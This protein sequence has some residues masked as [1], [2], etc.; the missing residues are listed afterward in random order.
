MGRNNYK[1]GKGQVSL[2]MALLLTTGA[3]LTAFA[4]SGLNATNASEETPAPEMPKT[5]AVNLSAS[6]VLPRNLTRGEL[7]QET[8]FR[9][10]VT[11]TGNTTAEIVA[12][13]WFLSPGIETILQT[14][15]CS[16]LE[17][18]ATCVAT[19]FVNSSLETAL[20]PNQIRGEV[21]YG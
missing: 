1:K 17:A 5:S 18:N 4:V 13:D 12:V 16:R 3:A 15:N 7:G 19:I 9:I 11:N 8:A 2:L 6:M 20:G 21:R 10:F 14:D